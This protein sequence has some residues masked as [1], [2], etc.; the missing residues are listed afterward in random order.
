MFAIDWHQI[1]QYPDFSTTCGASMGYA[2]E[3]SR[4]MC[5]NKVSSNVLFD[6]LAGSTDLAKLHN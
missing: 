4:E 6:A 3:N 1:Y 2:R 5:G